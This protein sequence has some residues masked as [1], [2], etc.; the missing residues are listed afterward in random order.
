MTQLIGDM[1]YGL[2][3]LLKSPVWTVVMCATLA[4]GVGLTTA[5]FSLT[6]TI[7]L[8]ALP[9]PNSERL[10]TLWTTSA[11][12]ARANVARFAVGAADWSDWRTQ[13]TLFED[14]GLTRVV[15]N[16]N[17]TGNGPPERVQGGRVTW[18]VSQVLGLQPV[19]GRMFTEEETRANAKVALV[20]YGF[21]ERRFAR[22]PGVL[23]RTIQLNGETFQIIGVMPREFRYPAKESEVWTPLFIPPSELAP[24]WGFNYRAVAR[25]KPGVS[26]QQAQE[27]MSAIM[28][29]LGEQYPT[30]NADLGVVVESLLDSS[31]GQFRTTLYAL[32]AAVGL[33]LLIACIN[34]GGLLVVRATARAREFVVR[35]ALGASVKRLR[36]QML[37]ESLPISI[38][39]AV[40]GELLAW[41]LVKV[42]V[43]WLPPQLPGLEFGLHWPVLAVAVLASVLVVMIAAMLPARLASR[44]QLTGA[45]QQESRTMTGGAG[46]RNAFVVAQ[47]SMTLVLVFASGLLVRSFVAAMKVDPG[48]L[49]QGVLTMQLAVTRAKYPTEQHVTSYYDRLM[50]RVRSVA[51]VT[52]VGMIS[53]LPFSEGRLSGPVYIEG[54]ADNDWVGANSRIVTPGYFSA[55]GIPLLRGRDF[56]EQDRADTSR[57]CVIDEQLARAVS[58]GADA[59]GKRVRFGVVNASTPWVEIVGVVGHVRDESLETDPR[60]QIYWVLNQQIQDRGALVIRTTGRPESFAP[61]VVEQIHTEDPDQPVYDIRSMGEW[62]DISLRSR[63]ML[64]GLV[65][66]FSISSLLLACLGLYGVVSYGATLRSREFAIRLALGARLADIRRLVF[67]HALWLWV[68]GSVIGL[69]IAWPVGRALRSLLYGV[70]AAD[71][72]SLAAA[73]A[74]L[75]VTSLLA[76]L[77]PAIRAGRVDPTVTLRGE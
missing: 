29:R 58:G 64:T 8:N 33:L 59:V 16:F 35:A 53:M 62:I 22:D 18:N 14:I 69:L 71:V 28:R 39:G 44:A 24:R 46:L 73:P 15:A 51:G 55:M 12:A 45:L 20:G 25:L 65:A 17:L 32:L 77:G 54:R 36:I 76:V 41:V 48:F 52:N 42:L 5:I 68:F 56:S 43:H 61:A 49:P 38:V 75:L 60:P 9:Y 1:R 50:T 27:E 6:Y 66:V 63:N 37:A 74:L 21:W 40:G 34:L 67:S 57:V 4:L 3:M 26:V 7:L 19:L 13:S 10:V 30:T 47:I 11:A 31:V 2:R 23:S 72:L 70:G